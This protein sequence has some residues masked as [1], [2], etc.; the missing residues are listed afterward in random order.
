MQERWIGDIAIDAIDFIMRSNSRR[1][2]GFVSWDPIPETLATNYT[3]DR[4][5]TF[6][7]VMQYL[8]TY[9]GNGAPRRSS[10]FRYY[11]RY[12]ILR[13][14]SAL[15]HVQLGQER[16]QH[17]DLGCGGGTFTHAMLELC[18]SRGVDFGKVTLYGYDYAPEMIRA[19]SRIHNY[20]Q[21]FIRS[22]CGRT[23]PDLYAY[24]E[25][26]A[27]LEAIPASPAELTHCIITIG[28]VL[29]NNPEAIN[30]FTDIITRIRST[31]GNGRCS[32]I[33]SDTRR[34]GNATQLSLRYEQLINSLQSSDINVNTLFTDFGVRIAELRLTA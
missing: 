34:S 16:I 10:Q 22:N 27:M 23:I 15:S 9:V 5:A 11:P 2:G 4:N 13:Y 26:E 31:T 28:Y 19:A 7:T 17:I 3:I 24:S 18:Q 20:I 14:K 29:F 30:S 8:W 21:Q 32:L 12:R 1:E 25:H 33:V 6:D